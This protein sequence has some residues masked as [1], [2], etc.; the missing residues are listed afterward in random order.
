[1]RWGILG[2]ALGGLLGCEAYTTVATP[3][4]LPSG[5]AGAPPSKLLHVQTSA[6]AS[7]CPPYDL[8]RSGSAGSGHFE[9]STFRYG[10]GR[11]PSV[12]PFCLAAWFDAND[13]GVI[14][15]GDAVGQLAEA[16]PD[17]PSNFIA[18]NHYESPPVTMTRVP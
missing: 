16:Y 1:M 7:P 4:V 6:P 14:D 11:I 10:Q 3:I 13:N 2:F 15:S 9:G 18:S 17:Q 5:F 12:G 8:S